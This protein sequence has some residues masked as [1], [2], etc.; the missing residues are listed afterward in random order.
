[1]NQEYR[2]ASD[3]TWESYIIH[4]DESELL[5]ETF[6][7]G[8]TNKILNDKMIEL[9]KQ[10]GTSYNQLSYNASS[11]ILAGDGISLEKVE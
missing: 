8:G 4:Y 1:M 9:D 7:E 3:G 11:K 2:F 10:G 5:S 6:L